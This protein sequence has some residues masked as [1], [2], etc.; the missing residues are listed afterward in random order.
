MQIL[1]PNTRRTFV[2]DPG[3]TLFDFDLDGADARVV[4]WDADERSMKDAFR[5][6]EKIHAR[7]ALDF[8][9]PDLAGP[10]GKKE[11]LYTRVKRSVHATNYGASPK[12]LAKKCR[13]PLSEA[14]DFQARYFAARPNIHE[15]MQA[16]EFE[17]QRCGGVSN[18]FGYS[19]N[20][21]QRGADAYT[22]ALAWRPQST[23]ARVT[24]I[25]M[26]RLHREVPNCQLLLQCHDS[27]VCQVRNDRISRTL[28]EIDAV[29]ST[30][31]VPYSD[32]LIVPWG[33][34]SSRKSWGE[35]SPLRWSDWIASQ[36]PLEQPLEQPVDAEREDLQAALP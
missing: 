29:F 10:D 28:R 5:R 17:L 6:G 4:A 26:L 35:L 30:I 1:T 36:Q 27:L 21:F 32:P 11:P 2:P 8:Y 34:K 23:I 24:E 31:V 20:F 25:A 16:I 12:V 13:M 19:I 3:Y 14:A 33:A 9:G 18:I 22:E 7:N 15:W